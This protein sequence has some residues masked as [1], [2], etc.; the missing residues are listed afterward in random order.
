MASGRGLYLIK[1]VGPKPSKCLWLGDR[2][3][4]AVPSTENPDTVLVHIYRRGAR[5]VRGGRCKFRSCAARLALGGQ[6]H[7]LGRGGTNIIS[8]PAGQSLLFGL[9]ALAGGKGNLTSPI[10]A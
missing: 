9:F 5:T 4:R 1:L 8:Q 10:H 2:L 7:K 6:H 3:D